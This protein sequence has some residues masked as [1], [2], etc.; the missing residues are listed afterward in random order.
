MMGRAGKAL[1][2]ALEANPDVLL[3]DAKLR[4]VQAEYSQAKLKVV[5]DVTVA[6]Y[7]RSM[8]QQTLQT[9]REAVK[10]VPGSTSE[11]EIQRMSDEAA[12]SEAKLA[13]L[14]GTRA[15]VRVANRSARYAIS[16]ASGFASSS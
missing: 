12:E 15:Q 9:H 2:Q 7:E 4:Q 8:H 3:A 5:Q 14:L 10:K 13:Y 1:A 11:L 6:F 16:G